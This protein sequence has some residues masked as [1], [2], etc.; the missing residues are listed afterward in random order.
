MSDLYSVS[1]S[2]VTDE[3]VEFAVS[4]VHPDAGPVS[5]GLCFALSLLADPLDEYSYGR[6]EHVRN[7]PLFS[8]ID[9][10]SYLSEDFIRSNACGFV[11][12][13]EIVGG[14]NHPPPSWGDE[15]Y[16]EFWDGGTDCWAMLRIT[17]THPGWIAHLR[18]GMCWD[19]AAYDCYGEIPWDRPTRYPGDKVKQVTDDPM[20]GMREETRN[21]HNAGMLRKGC[22]TEFI[23][24]NEGAKS[25][26]AKEKLEGDAI[27]PEAIQALLGEPVLVQTSG[28]RL[29]IGALVQADD[30][31]GFTVYSA[32]GGS[33]SSRGL[34]PDSVD[35]IGRAYYLETFWVDDLEV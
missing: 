12:S 15:N 21:S 11:A 35:W 20:M 22:V 30:K 19:T 31:G 34:S 2:T 33:Q 24:P 29:E 14:E 8:E 1:V 18:E 13:S 28:G 6:E 27:T 25:Y 5:E 23:L 26:T 16:E 7:S 10:E 9:L 3:Y 32:H 17:P 4:V